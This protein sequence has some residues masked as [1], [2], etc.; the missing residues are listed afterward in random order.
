MT[1]RVALFWPGDY[2]DYPNQQAL[3]TEFLKQYASQAGLDGAAFDACLASSKYQQKVQDAIDLGT[4]FGVSSTPTVF[5]N[6]RVVNGAQ[7]LEVFVSVIDEELAR[8]GR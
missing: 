7:P 2:R 1:Q 5:V 3:Q 4:R 6:G 8:A